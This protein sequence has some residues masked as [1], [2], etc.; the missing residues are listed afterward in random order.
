MVEIILK[1]E[2]FAIIGTAIE[3]H[4]ISVQAFLKLFTK[5]QWRLNRLHAFCLLW[6]KRPFVLI[7]K[8]VF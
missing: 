1:D 7:T 8:V 6:R 3:V 4:R 5:K 2:V